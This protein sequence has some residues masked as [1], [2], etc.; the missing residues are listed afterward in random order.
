MLRI[1][2]H[3]HLWTYDP[4]EY[5]WLEGDLAM[6]RRNFLQVDLMA[7]MQQAGVSGTVAVQARQTVQETDWLLRLAADDPLVLGVVGWLPLRD[8][9]LGALLERYRAKRALKGLR[10]VVQDEAP[11]FMDERAFNAGVALLKGCGM[12]YDILILADQLEEATRLVDRHP[13][14]TF[15]LDHLA[16]PRIAKGEMQPWTK[17]IRELARRD[18]VVCKVSGMVTEADPKQWSPAQL[19]PYFDIVLDCFTPSRVMAAS[20]WPVLC[21]GCTPKRWWDVLEGWVGDL[22]LDEQA[23][24]M[25]KTAIRTYGLRVPNSVPHPLGEQAIPHLQPKS[26]SY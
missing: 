11:G 19:K 3:H 17:R 1:D 5:G 2:A 20:D 4:E 7:A 9:N 21:A 24:V 6:L 13:N 14:Q 18:N 26:Q 15:V 8:S 25:G 10:H 16:K 23:D 22:S 12:A